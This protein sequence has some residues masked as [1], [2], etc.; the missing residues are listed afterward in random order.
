[1]TERTLLDIARDLHT[2]DNRI[3]HLPI[4]VLEEK[5]R[6][7]GIDLDYTDEYVWRDNEHNVVWE[8]GDKEEEPDDDKLMKIG[9]AY[10]WQFRTACLTENG[11]KRHLEL[12]G[13]NLGETRIYVHSGY[14]TPEIETL[15]DSIMNMMCDCS[16]HMRP[17]PVCDNDE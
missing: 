8:T 15:R 3:T 10:R 4:F 6:I 14:R 13:H 17:C 9:I 2:Q 16:N 12:N 5:V 11:I 1:M 7:W